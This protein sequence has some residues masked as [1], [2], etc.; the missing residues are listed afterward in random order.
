MGKQCSLFSQR[1]VC[2]S[3][4]MSSEGEDGRWDAKV[5][6]DRRICADG[7]VTAHINTAWMGRKDQQCTGDTAV[8]L[9]RMFK[10]EQNDLALHEV[11]T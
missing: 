4:V 3:Y 9:K 1:C 6:G 2:V 11:I 7:L 5:L 8:S 10:S